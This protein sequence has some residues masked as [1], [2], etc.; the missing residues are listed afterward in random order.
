MLDAHIGTVGVWL[1]FVACITGALLIVADLVARRHELYV[2]PRFGPS[3]SPSP[4]PSTASR[5]GDGRWL[6]PVVLVGALLAVGA[7]EHALVTHDFLALRCTPFAFRCARDTG[8]QK[9]LREPAS[10]KAS[11]DKCLPAPISRNI[12]ATVSAAPECA[13]EIVAA[14]RIC[15]R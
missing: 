1:A 13:A 2:E 6:A 14:P 8:A 12:G 3:P 7:M 5:F 9:W 15:M 11:V 10:L 4:S